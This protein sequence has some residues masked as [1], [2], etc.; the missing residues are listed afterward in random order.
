MY[1]S[2]YDQTQLKEDETD[3]H[4]SNSWTALT[5]SKQ[6][7]LLRLWDSAALACMRLLTT[8]FPAMQ[9]AA[10]LIVG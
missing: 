5:C 10:E 4:H 9:A 1:E 7:N 3:Y 2:S 6:A 8:L